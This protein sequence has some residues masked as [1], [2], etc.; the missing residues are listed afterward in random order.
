[1]YWP[2]NTLYIEKTTVTF[3][4]ENAVNISFSSVNLF[5]YLIK[6]AISSVINC[7]DKYGHI[8]I[9]L[10]VHFARYHC[11]ELKIV[12]SE[13][14]LCMTQFKDRKALK[15]VMCLLSCSLVDVTSGIKWE[16]K[17]SACG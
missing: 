6:V 7:W 3:E 5:K 2:F 8:E 11:M 12:L 10:F 14:R 15:F 13:Y 16:T 1:M 4:Y 17:S 9:T